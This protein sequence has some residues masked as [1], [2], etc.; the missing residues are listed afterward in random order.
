MSLSAQL[1]DI[2]AAVGM[3]SRSQ[4]ASGGIL[5][6][7]PVDDIDFDL[8]SIRDQHRNRLSLHKTS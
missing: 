4:R 2:I 6:E 3:W 7:M 5:L 8:F 1:S